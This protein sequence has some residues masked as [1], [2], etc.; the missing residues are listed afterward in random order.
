MP[1]HLSVDILDLQHLLL[2]VPDNSAQ[3]ISYAVYLRVP[4]AALGALMDEHPNLSEDF[5]RDTVIGA[6]IYREWV[7][8]VGRRDADARIAHMLLR[9]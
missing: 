7:L 3:V 9:V 4:K 6:S 1:F 2:E 8:N 5:A